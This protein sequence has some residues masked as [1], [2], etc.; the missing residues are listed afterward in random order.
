MIVIDEKKREGYDH[1]AILKNLVKVRESWDF[2]G[3]GNRFFQISIEDFPNSLKAMGNEVMEMD[4]S[5]NFF[6]LIDDRKN[7]NRFFTFL[8]DF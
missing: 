8:H 4:D 5:N 1:E 3:G 7:R 6:V 2:S